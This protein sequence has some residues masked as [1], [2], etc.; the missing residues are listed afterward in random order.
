[1]LLAREWV[2]A[3]ERCECFAVL[4]ACGVLVVLQLVGWLSLEWEVFACA[5][6]DR[7]CVVS[8]NGRSTVRVRVNWW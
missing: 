7:S 4:A 2:G 6:S 1:V 3:S 8:L 5:A